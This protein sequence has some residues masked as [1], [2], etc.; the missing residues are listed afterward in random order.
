MG[1]L[2]GDGKPDLVVA[3]GTRG[4]Q[5]DNLPQHQQSWKQLRSIPRSTSRLWVSMRTRAF[6]FPKA[7]DR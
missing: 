6:R 1:D 4:A 2:D 3:D 7:G 5:G